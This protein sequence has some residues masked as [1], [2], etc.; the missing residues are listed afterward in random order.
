MTATVHPIGR[1]RP[2]VGFGHR[3]RII[4]IEYGRVV[5]KRTIGQKEFAALL[6]EPAGNYAGYEAPGKP[7]RPRELVAFCQKVERLTGY[8]ASW[9]AGFD[10]LDGPDGGPT[11][12]SERTSGVPRTGSKRNR[13][14]LVRAVPEAHP[15]AA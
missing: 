7:T 1:R 5:L 8:D 3:L 12:A 9:L 13:M 14:A 4:R 11:E 6:D 15:K 10:I 2:D